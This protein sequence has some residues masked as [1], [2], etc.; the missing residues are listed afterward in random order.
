MG[1]VVVV[2]RHF[3]LGGRFQFYLYLHQIGEAQL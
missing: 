2:Y 1:W 3:C